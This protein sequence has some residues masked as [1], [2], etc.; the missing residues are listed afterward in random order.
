MLAAVA[1]MRRVIA[2]TV[3]F[4]AGLALGVHQPV[5]GKPKQKARRAASGEVCR[6]DADCALVTDGC[7]N[8]NQGGKQR[9]I[10]SRGRSAYEKRRKSICQQIM[11]PALM[12]EDPSCVAGHAVCKDGACTLGL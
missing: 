12:S 4:F 7:C 11:C 2:L 10:L 6:A 9:A 5:E 8:C 1:P 3:L